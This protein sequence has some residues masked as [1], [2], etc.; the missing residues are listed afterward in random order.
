MLLGLVKA[1]PQPA[2][3]RLSP[4]PASKPNETN[5]YPFSAHETHIRYPVEMEHGPV[6]SARYLGLAT[7]RA[8]QPLAIPLLPGPFFNHFPGADHLLVQN[9]KRPRARRYGPNPARRRITNR[10]KQDFEGSRGVQIV[11]TPSGF[12]FFT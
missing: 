7:T 11:L 1:K 10:V 12:C 4:S 2:E 5:E 6:A 8:V 3:A 9:K